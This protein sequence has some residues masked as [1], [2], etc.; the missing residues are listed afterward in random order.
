MNPT[1]LKQRI[2]SLSADAGFEKCAISPAMAVQRG[3]YYRHWLKS[4]RAGKMDYLHRNTELRTDV[5]KL[6]PGAK[7]VIVCALNYHQSDPMT[8]NDPGRP[9]GKV[10]MYAWGG[11][12]HKIIK[13][14]LFGIVDQ[15]RSE[16]AMPFETKVCVDTAPILEREYAAMSGIGWIGKNT[17]VLDPTLG[18]YFFLGLIVTTLELPPDSP[19]PDHCGSCTRCLDACPTDAFP[20]AYEMD[21]SRCISYLTIELRDETVPDALA[22]LMGDWVFGCDVCQQVCPHNNDVPQTQEPKFAI[23]PPG[24][25][26]D[27]EAMKNMT[28]DEFREQLKG[29]AIKRAKPDMLRRNARIAL[30]NHARNAER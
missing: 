11:D 14:K 19:S 3:D 24:P 17:L 1:D 15:L 30:A 6:L 13:R 22:P 8:L 10:A 21:A 18:S 12:Y 27:L 2:I 5:G 9:R 20:A 16:V 7:S 26:P 4:G 23:R 29:S 25:R 28:D